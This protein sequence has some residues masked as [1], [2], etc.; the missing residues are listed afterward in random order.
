MSRASSR[1]CRWSSPAR[2]RRQQPS[3]LG[4]RGDVALDEDG[5]AIRIEPRREQHRGYVERAVPKRRRIVRHRDRVQVDDAEEGFALLLRGC[6][7]A[8][9]AAEVADVGIACRL[10]AAE[11]AHGRAPFSR[12]GRNASGRA[13][14][15]SRRARSRAGSRRA[16]CARPTGRALAVRESSVSGYPA[17]ARSQTGCTCGRNV[18]HLALVSHGSSGHVRGQSLDVSAEALSGGAMAAGLAPELAGRGS[19]PASRPLLH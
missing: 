17:G 5:R 12:A 1:C 7:L 16:R 4:V 6:V 19:R 18:T 14:G 2:H 13:G 10:D 9:A 11:D 15:L 8:E 3:R